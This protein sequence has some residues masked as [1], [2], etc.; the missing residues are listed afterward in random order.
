MNADSAR[1]WKDGVEVAIAFLEVAT[2]QDVERLARAVTDALA[3]T[4][5]TLIDE[6]SGLH[7]TEPAFARALA[8][9]LRARTTPR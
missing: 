7:G 2:R 4:G 8:A 6:A 1:K 9:A 3:V 5:Y